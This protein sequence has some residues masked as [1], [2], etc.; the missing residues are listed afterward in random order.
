MFDRNA[1]YQKSPKGAEAIATRS[2]ALAP[3]A[4]SMLILVD[5]KR[6]F[7]ELA[8]LGQML[9]D[10]ERLLQDLSE[11]GLIEPAGGGERRAAGAASSPG[12]TSPAQAAAAAPAHPPVP[13]AQAQR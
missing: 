11:Q 2:A 7:A 5:G 3:K 12:A 6:S 10:P 9:G 1:T 4:R 13:L 8:R